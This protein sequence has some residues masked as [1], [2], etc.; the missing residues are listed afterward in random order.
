[1]TDEYFTDLEAR[2][3]DLAEQLRAGCRALADPD[4]SSP[5]EH[6]YAR[7]PADLRQQLRRHM[8]FVST[9]P[10]DGERK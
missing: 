5:F 8:E 3:R 9:G 10:Q 4:A 1:M 6:T 2:E 7:M